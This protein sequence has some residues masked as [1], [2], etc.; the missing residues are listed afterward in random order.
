VIILLTQGQQTV[1]DDE[2][3]H[4]VEDYKWYAVKGRRD[5]YYAASK[6]NGKKVSMH[7]LLTGCVPFDKKIVDHID[8]DGLNNRRVNLRVGGYKQNARNKIRGLNN[9]TGKTGIYYRNDGN[10]ERFTTA[11]MVNGRLKN[12]SFEITKYGRE[13]A[14]IMACEWRNK[15]EKKMKILTRDNKEYLDSEEVLTYR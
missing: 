2:D 6:I 1:I 12:K 15:M 13:E 7:R 5:N 11:V 9:T 3:W 10:R 8:G 4:L 14:M